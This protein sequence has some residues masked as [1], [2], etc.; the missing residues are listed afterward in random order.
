MPRAYGGPRGGAVSYER[1]TPPYTRLLMQVVMSLAR[2]E[3]LA[4]Q[5]DPHAMLALAACLLDEAP[6]PSISHPL[7]LSLSLYLTRTL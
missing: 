3:G 7:S 2:L 1:V 4:L 5:K 6:P